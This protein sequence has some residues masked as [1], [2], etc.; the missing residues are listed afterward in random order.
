MG[1]NDDEEMDKIM[2]D[3]ETVRAICADTDV[4]IDYLRVENPE[5]PHLPTGGRRLRFL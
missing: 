2:E 5:N 1:Q 4:I 3:V